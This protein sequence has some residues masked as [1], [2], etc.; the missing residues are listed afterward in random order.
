MPDFTG[1]GSCDDVTGKS[2]TIINEMIKFQIRIGRL[3]IRQG[4]V[5]VQERS[6]QLLVSLR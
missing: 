6:V 4:R 3:N 1:D 2:S 5:F